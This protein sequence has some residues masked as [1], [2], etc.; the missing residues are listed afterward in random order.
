VRFLI[1]PYIGNQEIVH[2]SDQVQTFY[3]YVWSCMYVTDIFPDV[4]CTCP[5]CILCINTGPYTPGDISSLWLCPNLGPAPNNWTRLKLHSQLPTVS[6]PFVSPH[7]GSVIGTPLSVLGPH[8]P[9]TRCVTDLGVGEAHWAL[10][11]PVRFT[12]SRIESLTA[13]RRTWGSL[14]W[15]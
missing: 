14:G 6:I 12:I 2:L 15:L 8:T 3:G 13:L 10:S 11:I 5:Y 4:L 1:W 7:V 9:Y